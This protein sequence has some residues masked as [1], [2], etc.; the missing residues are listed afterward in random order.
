[1]ILPN[2]SASTDTEIT[3][4][5]IQLDS[6]EMALVGADGNSVFDNGNY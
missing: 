1:M 4:A 3:A 5:L 2:G 6:Q